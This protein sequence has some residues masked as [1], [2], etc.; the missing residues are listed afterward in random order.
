MGIEVGGTFTD[1]VASGPD[2][3]I[4]ARVPTTPEEP[5]QGVIAAL[6][7]AGIEPGAI[8]EFSHGSTVA[9]DAVLERRGARLALLITEGFR[10]ILLLGRQGRE[11]IFEPAHR[12]AE[13]LVARG[14][15]LEVPERILADGSVST[16]LATELFAPRLTA[17]LEAGGFDGVAICLLNA[18]V[19]PSHEHDLAAFI[20]ARWPSL[21]VTTS[22]D[23]AREFREHERASTTTL[24]AYV[25]PVLETYLGEIE[26]HLRTAGF[27]GP[28]SMMQS[29]G[30]RAPV[31]TVRRNGASALFSG[32]AAGVTGAVR[33]AGLSGHRDIITL[34][35]GGTSAD[36]C[37]VENGRPEIAS[38]STIASLPVQLPMVD[39]T[40]I[41]AGG[42]A[43]IF[44]DE[45][46]M[47]RVG[48]HS[49]GANPGPACYGR[50]GTRPTVTDAHVVCGRIAADARLASGPPLDVAAARAAFA[51]L[52]DTL[53]LS[54]EEVAEGAVNIAVAN[55]VT[56]IDFI[57]TRRGR[58]PH[59]YVLVPYG[60]AGPLHAVAVADSLSIE[61][62]LVPPRAG[63]ISAYGLLTADHSLFASRTR[64]ISVEE[65][66]SEIVHEI[67]DELKTELNADADRMALGPIRRC[68]VTLD[69]R[70]VG[71]AFEIAVRLSEELA[72]GST[73]ALLRAAFENAY[74][75]AYRLGGIPAIKVVEVVTTRVALHIT[76][77]MAP[78][79]ACTGPHVASAGEVVTVFGGGRHHEARRL[80][81]RAVGPDGLAG[82]LV[83]DDQTTTV[84]VPGGW[85]ASMDPVGNLILGKIG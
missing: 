30:G 32:P 85:A 5:E 37:L 79:L 43:I 63:A 65:G 40:T 73:P 8:T 39:V 74:G 18:F 83:L 4:F 61:T 34:D 54:V 44:V 20:K 59:D 47:L 66:A 50:G 35:I 29:H 70:Y 3:L 21:R 31:E 52:A 15:T 10:D 56:A 64:R 67:I 25:Q 2:G 48:P 28:F 82:P 78:T 81:R 27:T 19:N 76:E 24:A 49:A 72:A 17:F 13:P 33:L 77:G 16:R 26:T 14:D 57:S 80:P 36:V 45:T 51:E 84:F 69:M 71:Q 1:L 62:V 7:C 11:V 42:G 9:T 75:A 22:C 46:G 58:D 12:K 41:G 6:R 68:D 38:H 60:G 53:A 55:I 23:V